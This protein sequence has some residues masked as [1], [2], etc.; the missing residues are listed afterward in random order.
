MT[1][2]W[3]E[4]T[5]ADLPNGGTGTLAT[6][7]PARSGCATGPD[8]DWLSARERVQLNAMHFAKRRTEWQLG[9][10][11]AKLAVAA[12]LQLP[13]DLHSL[14][15]IEVRSSPSGAP[16]TFLGNKWA[17]VTISLS[18]RDGRAI[19][20]VATDRG[21]AG[22]RSGGHRAAQRGFYRRLFYD[23][24]TRA[25][26]ASRS[27]GPALP[28]DSAL[29]RQR[30]RAQSAARGASPRYSKRGRHTGRC[31]TRPKRGRRSAWVRR[32]YQEL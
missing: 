2:Y 30:E 13:A 7:C 17:P 11:T 15:G 32:V 19:C 3:L 16:E 8:P 1:V 4:Q 20:A 23:G 24:G 10:W 29:E 5:E 27:G 31:A 14:A 12:C 21:T 6:A 22:L 9:R 18:H 26:G 28:R 25:G